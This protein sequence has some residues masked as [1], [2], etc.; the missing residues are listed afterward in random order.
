MGDKEAAVKARASKARVV[1]RKTNELNNAIKLEVL[2]GEINEKV[3]KLKY[4]MGE[5]GELHDA[6]IENIEEGEKYEEETATE[7]KMYYKYDVMVN[8]VIKD[9]NQYIQKKEQERNLFFAPQKNSA[10][11]K[12]ITRSLNSN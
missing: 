8:N 11:P 4:A 3:Q 5:L 9:A 12:K 1:S 6:V 2:P 7:D 10:K